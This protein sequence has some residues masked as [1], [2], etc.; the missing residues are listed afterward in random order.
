MEERGTRALRTKHVVTGHHD[1][2]L[3]TST[4]NIIYTNNNNVREK[5]ENILVFVLH[6]YYNNDNIWNTTQHCQIPI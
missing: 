1:V 2:C 3:S 5:Y 6:R 4:Y